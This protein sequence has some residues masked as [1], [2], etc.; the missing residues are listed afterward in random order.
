MVLLILTCFDFKICLWAQKVTRPFQET[1]P[2]SNSHQ[3][4]TTVDYSQL[5]FPEDKRFILFDIVTLLCCDKL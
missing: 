3:I 5:Y 4:G 2:W 1:G